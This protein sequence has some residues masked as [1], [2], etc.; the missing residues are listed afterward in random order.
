MNRDLLVEV[1]AASNENP[2][3]VECLRYFIDFWND[4]NRLL[5]GVVFSPKVLVFGD[6]DP[7]LLSKYR[8]NVEQLSVSCD[9]AF[10]SQNAR[11]L[12]GGV[13]KA[14]IVVTSDVD[15][16][17]LDLRLVRRSILE[18]LRE[19]HTLVVSRNVLPEGQ[20]PICYSLARP[21]TWRK[22]FNIS[23]KEEL[24]ERLDHLW[25]KLAVGSGYSG[26]H[27]GKGWSFDQEYLYTEVERQR[28]LSS[29]KVVKLADS[30][31]GHRRLDRIFLRGYFRWLQILGVALSIYTDYHIHHP[32]T[33]YSTF[34]NTVARV[35]TV[36]AVKS[37][38][39]RL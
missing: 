13:S 1:V 16:L 15:M 20:Y 35:R 38:L 21:I 29:I 9:T 7:E 11:T 36:F 26:A 22:V 10:A 33:R 3:Y 34:V 2:K 37:A 19:E 39:G 12:W 28:L 18:C 25:G 27:G 24:E 32:V 30:D 8:D 31:T 6:V 23:T 5:E 4:S 14:D 17:P